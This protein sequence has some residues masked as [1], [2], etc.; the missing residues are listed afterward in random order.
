MLL[1]TGFL[2]SIQQCFVSTAD[3]IATADERL[4]SNADSQTALV[5][6]RPRTSVVANMMIVVAIGCDHGG[7][8]V[9]L[10]LVGP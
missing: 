7:R 5:A 3:Y 4:S 2:A 10:P 6:P 9:A 8:T 1:A